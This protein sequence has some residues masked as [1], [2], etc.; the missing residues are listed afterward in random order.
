VMSLYTLRT[1]IEILFRELKQYTSIENFHSQ[2]LNGVLFGFSV[3]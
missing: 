1:M 2:S 3:R